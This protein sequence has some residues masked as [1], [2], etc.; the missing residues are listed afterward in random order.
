MYAE[1]VEQYLQDIHNQLLA[2]KQQFLQTDVNDV[3]VTLVTAFWIII[4]VVF[5]V[6]K[7]T[8]SR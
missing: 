5:M 2:I 4:I 7:L 6:K 8:S 1:T 3:G